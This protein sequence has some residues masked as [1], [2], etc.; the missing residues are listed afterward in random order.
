[1]FWFIVG[2]LV[3]L[4][5]LVATFM[6][7]RLI[8]SSQDRHTSERATKKKLNSTSLMIA[9]AGLVL[10]AILIVA[11]FVVVLQPGEVGIAYQLRG[12]SR[13]LQVGYNFVAPWARMHR[14]DTT[15]QIVTFSQGDA[16]DD[17]YG[18]QTTEKD[19]IEVVATIGVHI[20][21]SKM[22]EYIALY[23][24]EQ[25][26]SKR[27]TKLLKTISRNSIESIIGS[28]TTSEVM[29]NK[30]K[31]GEE[32]STHLQESIKDLPIILDSFTIDDLVA[33]ESY[34]LA[35]K[36]QAQLRMEKEKATLQQQ[37]NEQE[38]LANKTKAEGDAAVLKTQ[39]EADAAVKKIEA[40]NAASVA[41]IKADNDAEVKKI[42]AEA[43]A[44]VRK[45]QAEAQATEI[46]TKA[47]AEAE[48]TIKKGE[49]E[50]KAI[51][52]QGE[53][54]NQNPQLIDLKKAEISAEVQSKWAENWSG[55]SF[56]GM[57][58]FNFADL[59][60]ILKNLINPAIPA[61]VPAE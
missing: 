6:M 35:I 40:E 58:G 18:A 34:E 25:I 42:Q 47:N 10:S 54:Y 11:S 7:P 43:E 45:T 51:A 2:L 44:S 28:Y 39:A 26:S 4:A 27:I 14:W 60:E 8:E 22:T 49:A 30:K 19:Y 31:I 38:A 61:V 55:Y 5:T 23:G 1:M 24:N 17:I 21:T 50:A 48:A 59:T 52:A 41:K 15:M 32:A 9:L 53:A 56:E 29:G 37:I 12:S 36:E 33:P 3:L 57:S 16:A 13:E 46:T 20:D